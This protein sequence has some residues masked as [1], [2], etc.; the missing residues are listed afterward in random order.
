MLLMYLN[1]VGNYLEINNKYASINLSTLSRGNYTV[2][3]QF[4]GEGIYDSTRLDNAGSF[5]VV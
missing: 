5:S 3:L 4:V 1:D 2:D